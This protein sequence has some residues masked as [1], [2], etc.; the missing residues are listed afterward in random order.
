MKSGIEVK[1]V[2]SFS[3]SKIVLKNRDIVDS[4]CNNNLVGL[5]GKVVAIISFSILEPVIPILVLHIPSKPNN[6][7]GELRFPKT[8]YLL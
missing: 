2:D 7:K 1:E 8:Q 5:K 3:I 4:N 6:T